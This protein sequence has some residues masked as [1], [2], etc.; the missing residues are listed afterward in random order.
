MTY[1]AQF[2]H[3][4]PV[5]VERVFLFFANPGN[6]PRIMPPQ[7][8]TELITV[9]LVAPPGVAAVQS[10]VTDHPPLAG[11]GTEIVTA[12]RMIPFLPFRAR[13]IA[14]I[15]EFEWN[16]HFADI[17]KKGPFQRF[18]HRHEFVGEVRN[19]VNGTIVRDVI[20]YEIGFGFLGA[21]AQKFFVGPQLQKA[22]EYRQTALVKLLS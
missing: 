21:L 6:L 18:H 11:V 12:F 17:Q 13:W 19:G 3:W 22:F 1:H 9:K 20:E 7:T 15:T 16:H 10:T 2:V 8:G 4:V 14:L 5:P